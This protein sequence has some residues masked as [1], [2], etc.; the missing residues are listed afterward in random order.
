MANP[1]SHFCNLLPLAVIGGAD[2][3]AVIDSSKDGSPHGERLCVIWNPPLLNIAANAI[4][5]ES[6][7]EKDE[8]STKK[9]MSEDS[10]EAE[11]RSGTTSSDTHSASSALHTKGCA[12]C[13]GSKCEESSSS[14]SSSSS[15]KAVEKSRSAAGLDGGDNSALSDFCSACEDRLSYL[16]HRDPRGRG[17]KRKPQIANPYSASRDHLDDDGID[18]LMMATTGE[19]MKR[20]RLSSITEASRL[21]SALVRLRV[22]TLAFCGVRKL[23]E[24]V[25][26]YS[27]KDLGTDRTSAH[28]TSKIASYRGGYSKEERRYAGTEYCTDASSVN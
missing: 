16:S 8:G 28:L 19:S 23:V 10:V 27:M 1:L 22:R 24:L 21:F 17:W 14:S 20:Q 3:V 11:R 15:T 25:L 4:T 18:A 9:R 5:K 7:K 13:C 26:R 12:N 6:V 2:S